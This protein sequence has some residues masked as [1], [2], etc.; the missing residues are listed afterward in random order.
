MDPVWYPLDLTDCT[1]EPTARRGGVESSHDSPLAGNGFELSVPHETGSGFEVSSEFWTDRCRR[2][3]MIRAA[4]VSARSIERFRRL[5][6]RTR[7]RMKAPALSAGHRGTESLRTFGS[8]TARRVL[9]RGCTA[10]AYCK[11]DSI[12]PAVS[13]ANFCIAPLARPDLDAGRAATDDTTSS[14]T[15]PTSTSTSEPNHTASTAPIST[16]SSTTRRARL[17]RQG[18]TT[19]KLYNHSQAPNPR[20]VRIFMAEKGISLMRAGIRL[21]PRIGSMKGSRYEAAVALVSARAE[22]TVLD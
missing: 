1:L 15:A 2:G 20:R 7:R 12:P 21:A 11:F 19:M 13:H 6:E 16:S 17:N 10:P 3:G 8:G 9:P 4:S 22:Q 5:E 18:G 14:A